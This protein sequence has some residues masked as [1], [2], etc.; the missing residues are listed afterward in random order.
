MYCRS[1]LKSSANT[2]LMC[3]NEEVLQ[4]LRLHKQFCKKCYDRNLRSKK[5]S[6][7]KSSILHTLFTEIENSTSSPPEVRMLKRLK[8]ISRETNGCRL[9]HMEPCLLELFGGNSPNG[10]KFPSGRL[11]Q[12][13]NHQ[14]SYQL[15]QP[16]GLHRISAGR[17]HAI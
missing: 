11:L 7:L 4:I 15:Q 1:F 2:K 17:Q 3:E 12:K 10:T 16:R 8:Q 14:I 13:P 6:D 9:F 5:N